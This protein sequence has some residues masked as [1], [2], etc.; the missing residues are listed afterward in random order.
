MKHDNE[1]FINVSF[2]LL[3]VGERQKPIETEVLGHRNQDE[4]EI[5]PY[6]PWHNEGKC[7]TSRAE[8]IFK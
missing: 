6:V 1:A 5:H 7:R 8:I 4:F 3:Q 2:L